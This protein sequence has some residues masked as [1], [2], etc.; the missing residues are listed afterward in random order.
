MNPAR[1]FGKGSDD[2]RKLQL[3]DRLD[4]E[5]ISA[6]GIETE[7]RWRK[8][9][10]GGSAIASDRVGESRLADLVESACARTS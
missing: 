4:L 8:G 7:P 6:A 2:V 9:V 5:G 10:D 1:L 3:L